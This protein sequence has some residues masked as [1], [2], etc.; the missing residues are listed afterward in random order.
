[1]SEVTSGSET[2]VVE[3]DVASPTWH[4]RVRHDGAETAPAMLTAVVVR[5][6][7]WQATT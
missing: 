2:G 6:G 1:M 7:W 5:N 4:R 3:A